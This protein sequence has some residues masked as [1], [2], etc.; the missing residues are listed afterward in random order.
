[1]VGDHISKPLKVS[2]VLRI[3]RCPEKS[4]YL[5]RD[6]TAKQTIAIKGTK[7]YSSLPQN[8]GHHQIL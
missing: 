2:K 6:K 7:G 5:T 3:K 8:G 4:L 1:M